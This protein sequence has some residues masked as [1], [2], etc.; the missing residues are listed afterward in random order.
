MS[1]SDFLTVIPS[2]QPEREN[3]GSEADTLLCQRHQVQALASSM[4]STAHSV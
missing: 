1:P 3:P 2:D 4:P